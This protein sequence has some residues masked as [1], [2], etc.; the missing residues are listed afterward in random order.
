MADGHSLLLNMIGRAIYEFDGFGFKFGMYSSSVTEKES[1]CGI[2]G[3]L[4][5]MN[6]EGE[7]TT[8]ILQYFYGGAVAYVAYKKLPITVTLDL[9]ADWID[10]IG[11]AE[12]ARIL[13]DSL[14]FPK[15]S[16]AP[17]ETGQI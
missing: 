8:A 14:T 4:K 9:V 1:G 5:K 7:A 12:A 10:I 2:S 3:L 16:E 11:E 13:T 6:T 17:K 15:N